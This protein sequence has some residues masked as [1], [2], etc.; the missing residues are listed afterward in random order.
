M[1]VVVMGHLCLSLWSL[2]LI[3]VAILVVLLVGFSRVYSQSRFPH[4]IVGSWISGLIGLI[5]SLHCCDKISF[6]TYDYTLMIVANTT[7]ISFFY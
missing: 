3:P 1:A 2:G 4:Q 7:N 6:H 5:A